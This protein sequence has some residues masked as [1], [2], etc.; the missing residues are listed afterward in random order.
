MKLLIFP[1]LF[2]FACAAGVDRK[3]GTTDGGDADG[4][5]ADAEVSTQSTRVYAHTGNDLYAIDPNDLSTSFVGNF[6]E[7]P[8]SITD[9]AVS[10]NGA[11]VGVTANGVYSIDAGTAKPTLLTSLAEGAFLTALTFVPNP[12]AQDQEILIGV[13][14]DGSS[15]RINTDNGA[16]DFVGEYGNGIESSGDMVFVEN[17]GILATVANVPS[18]TPE[19]V[20]LAR[21]D[22]LT[23]KA[24]V[25]GDTGFQDVFG[26]GFWEDKVYGFTK[27]GEFI[28]I[29][30]VSGVG[31]L[32]EHSGLEWFGAGVTTKAPVQ[33]D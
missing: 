10:A 7:L 25:L 13:D 9:I 29:D 26:L 20:A 3:S 1:L 33:I 4:G 14:K 27:N 17:L 16:I 5:D 8:R 15:Y 23:F 19:K 11:I 30:P 31:T 24:T 28:L 2:C 21:I 12:V 6:G 18:M 32:R 22:P